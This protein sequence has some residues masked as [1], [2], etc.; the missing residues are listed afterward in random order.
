MRRPFRCIAVVLAATLPACRDALAPKSATTQVSIPTVAVAAGTS[1]SSDMRATERF[2]VRT[3]IVG[4][5]KPRASLAL[6]ATV[7]ANVSTQNAEVTIAFPEL[8]GTGVLTRA[9]RARRVGKV[10]S[11]AYRQTLSFA[12]L[13][14]QQVEL[15]VTV[16]KPGYYR[17]VVTVAQ[18]S[19]EPAVKD[20]MWVKTTAQ[21]E[22]WF[23]IDDAG[24]RV[25]RT[26]DE[27]ALPDSA[28]FEPGERH[29]LTGLAAI[30]AAERRA[31]RRKD[32]V[33]VNARIAGK[34]KK[35]GGSPAAF[36]SSTPR[37]LTYYNPDAGADQPLSGAIVYWQIHDTFNNITDS[38]YGQT[39]A[40]GVYPGPCVTY[41]AL[42]YAT[43][44]YS[45]ENNDVR[46]IGGAGS[47][48]EGDCDP[49][50]PSHVVE[51]QRSWLFS[52]Y[53]DFIPF[54]RGLLNVS[55]IRVDVVYDV[56]EPGAFYQSANDR[57]T[58]GPNTIYTDYGRF[59]VA[60][61]YG[62]AIHEKALGGIATTSGQCPSPH[63]LNG[64]YT[65]AC[66]LS[67]GFGDFLGATSQN[68]WD[69]YG[70]YIVIA[71]YAYTP[72]ANGSIQEAAVAAMMYDLTDSPGGDGSASEPWDVTSGERVA[73]TIRDCRVR[74]GSGF[75]TKVRGADDFVYCAERTIDPAVRSS[76]FLTRSSSTRAAAITA[77]ATASANWPSSGVR[78][79]WR[80]NL[81]GL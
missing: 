50:L 49:N 3:N 63:A 19:S 26:F 57:I 22:L 42:E 30:R 44:S 27:F 51:S 58:I 54:S 56:N 20:G 80:K 36:V 65:L 41:P 52:R 78:S 12:T 38:Y 55:R 23:V 73:A 6:T 7:V 76:F 71:D 70:Y 77:N 35:L 72:G 13:Q 47:W 25:T 11:S 18:R 46:V 24:G 31:A 48:Y 79:V 9:D 17:A 1:D 61:E 37:R 74:Y 45:L 39:D 69:V 43:V 5:L 14:P 21:E 34:T 4:S 66:A 81:Y 2:S 68:V 62:H 40:N 60:H 15:N 32:T 16:A 29:Y 33:A 10:V 28:D 64:Y 75:I 59:T 8:D 53:N 67:E